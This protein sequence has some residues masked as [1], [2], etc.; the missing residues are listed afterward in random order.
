MWKIS[1]VMLVT[2]IFAGLLLYKPYE[3]PAKSVA[4]ALP[5]DAPAGPVDA[6]LRPIAAPAGPVAA[7]AKPVDAPPRLA[8][9][10][11]PSAQAEVADEILPPSTWPRPHTPPP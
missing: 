7:P 4:V 8:N 9:V 6:L 11:P 2:A 3:L 10:A 5:I 1:I